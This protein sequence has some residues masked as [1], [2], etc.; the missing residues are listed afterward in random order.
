MLI[1]VFFQVFL[2][3][4]SQ[5][6][7]SNNNCSQ[8]VVSDRDVYLYFQRNGLFQSQF[9]RPV[10]DHSRAIEVIVQ[11][12]LRNII[13]V[14]EK[15]QKI[16]VSAYFF[17]AWYDEFRVWKDISPLNCVPTIVLPSKTTG[18]WRPSIALSTA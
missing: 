10:K 9:V 17:I 18:L 6:K 15:E 2:F 16:S 5:S 8:I 11:L 14:N 12:Y 7:C 3:L 4:V 13:F 1:F